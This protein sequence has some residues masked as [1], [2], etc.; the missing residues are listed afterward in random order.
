MA[1]LGTFCLFLALVAASWSL[2][3]SYNGWRTSDGVLI[4]SGERAL[5]AAWGLVLLAAALLE[6]LIFS[7]RFDLEYVA[8]YSN[9]ALPS[10]YKVAVLWAGQAGSLMFWLLILCSYGTALIGLNRRRN[11]PLM[12]V[13]TATLSCIAVFFL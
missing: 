12:P 3:A 11:R 1:D 4:K 9:R 13:V 6:M 10:V 5:V 2:L 8:S 7:D